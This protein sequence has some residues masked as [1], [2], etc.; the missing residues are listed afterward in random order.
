MILKDAK[1]CLKSWREHSYGMK[2]RRLGMFEGPWCLTTLLISCICAVPHKHKVLGSELPKSPNMRS[3]SGAQMLN[4]T[5]CRIDEEAGRDKRV[6]RSCTAAIALSAVNAAETMW[7]WRCLGRTCSMHV[8]YSSGYGGSG[9][10]T[11]T[12]PRPRS[13]RGCLRLMH[14]IKWCRPCWICLGRSGKTEAS[15]WSWMGSGSVHRISSA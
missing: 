14:S 12:M 15:S 2:R 6:S 11:V 1:A 10:V 13:S 5:S 8:A 3:Q 7:L 9:M 4:L